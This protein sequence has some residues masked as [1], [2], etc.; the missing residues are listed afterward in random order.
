MTLPLPIYGLT[1]RNNMKTDE[2]L[3]QEAMQNIFPDVQQQDIEVRTYESRFAKEYL[4]L[5]LKE[6]QLFTREEVIS[7]V[8][9]YITS[10]GEI[11]EIIQR[12]D[13]LTNN[14]MV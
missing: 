5:Y 10:E 9:A 13:S 7:V 11:G 8:D 4:R 12:L 14:G 1:Y 2:Q 3:L 6:H